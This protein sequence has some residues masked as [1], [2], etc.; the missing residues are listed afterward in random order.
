VMKQLMF[1]FPSFLPLPQH[2]KFSPICILHPL[3]LNRR[4]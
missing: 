4:L 1:P 3:A 2:Y